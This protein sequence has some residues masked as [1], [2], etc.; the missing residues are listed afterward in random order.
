MSMTYTDLKN[1][2]EEVTENTFTDAQHKLF[3]QLAEETL[4][5]AVQIP[6]LRKTDT[7]STLTS[8]TAT[9]TLPSDYLYTYSLAIKS[10]TNVVTY[11]VVKD[12]SFLLEAYPDQDTRGTPKYYAQYEEDKLVVVPTPSS[13]FSL[14]HTYGHYPTSLVDSAS[15]TWISENMSSA[16]LNGALVE[17]ARFMK[18]EPDVVAMYKEQLT[19]SITLYKQFGDGK[20]RSDVYRG[21]QPKVQ[22]N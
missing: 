11:L 13:S 3:T 9:L 10:D 14:I 15:T 6:A 7:T 5:N 22:V 8:G 18:A 20:L 19:N 21:G 17:A 2:V 12:N 1:N 16:L 4:L